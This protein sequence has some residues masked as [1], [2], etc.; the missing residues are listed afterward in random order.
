MIR[1]YSFHGQQKG[2]FLSLSESELPNSIE[3]I[4]TQPNGNAASIILSQADW[5]EACKIGHYS[6]YGNRF[7]WAEKPFPSLEEFSSE[8]TSQL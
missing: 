8:D 6:S 5:E 7:T 1:T 4:I 2:S 3:I